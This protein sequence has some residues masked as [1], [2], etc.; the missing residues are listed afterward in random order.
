MAVDRHPTQ[1]LG[2]EYQ[3]LVRENLNWELKVLESASE[4]SCRV[5]G[6][7]VIML[8]ANN[9]LNLATHH[10]RPPASMAPVQAVTDPSP[11]T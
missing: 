1:Y 11:A 4:P 10:S 6:K 9:Y 7:T 2:E 3:R 5:S 8:C